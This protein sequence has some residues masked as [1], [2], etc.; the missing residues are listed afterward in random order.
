[1]FL[2]HVVLPGKILI[3]FHMVYLH[4]NFY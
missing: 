4:N 3:H 1:M 2:F